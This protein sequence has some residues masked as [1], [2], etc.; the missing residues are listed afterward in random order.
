MQSDG[1]P[2]GL[3]RKKRIVILLALSIVSLWDCVTSALG[4]VTILG[5]GAT[6]ALVAVVVAVLVLTILAS[7][8]SIWATRQSGDFV[9]RFSKFIWIV[10]IIFD[11]YTSYVGNGRY[12]V[13]HS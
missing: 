7:T 8:P 2:T 9:A 5:S 4:V 13:K 6:Q 10:A 11:L 3:L 12:L 1:Q